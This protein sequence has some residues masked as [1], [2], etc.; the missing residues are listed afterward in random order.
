MKNAWGSDA[1]LAL[2]KW[3]RWKTRWYRYGELIYDSEFFGVIRE[4][5]DQLVPYVR[6][7]IRTVFSE[8]V[9]LTKQ[10]KIVPDF[11]VELTF[12][13][14]TILEYDMYADK[15]GLVFKTFQITGLSL[16][17]D[18]PLKIHFQRSDKEFHY[19]YITLN[20]PHDL[21]LIA[22][23]INELEKL[24]EIAYAEVREAREHDQKILKRMEDLVM[25]YKLSKALS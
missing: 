20:S 10:I 9:E 4:F 1:Y 11:G 14:R 18:S 19:D 7:T 8:L 22:Q 13:P 15:R 24:Y 16:E 6:R 3:I 23:L 17:T 21:H 25:P 2:G 5:G 12:S